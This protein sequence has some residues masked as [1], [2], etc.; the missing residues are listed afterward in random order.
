MRHRTEWDTGSIL[1][2]GETA[3]HFEGREGAET[4]WG[5]CQEAQAPSSLF[6]LC[7]GHKPDGLMSQA[8]RTTSL[9]WL[10]PQALPGYPESREPP[11]P[12]LTARA[13]PN[14]QRL[15]AHSWEGQ[16]AC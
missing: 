16:G 12:L 8:T 15:P 3:A 4:G 10:H 7:S 14:L 6:S 5:P 2:L 9:A 1:L 11:R 13:F